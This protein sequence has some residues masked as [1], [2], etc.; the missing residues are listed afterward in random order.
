MDPEVAGS[1]PVTHPNSSL[2]IFIGIKRFDSPEIVL[3]D[4]RV[5]L[6]SAAGG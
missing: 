1:K 6:G 3:F 2:V 5:S 4:A